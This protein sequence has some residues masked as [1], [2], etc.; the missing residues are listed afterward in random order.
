MP[1]KKQKK[2]QSPL[3][4]RGVMK[5]KIRFDSFEA[6]RVV[7]RCYDRVKYAMFSASVILH[8]ISDNN[9]ADELNSIINDT[10]NTA[11][12]DMEKAKIQFQTVLDDAGIE[13]MLDYTEAKSYTFE[14]DSPK[15]SQYIKAINTLDDLVKM[16]DTAW[17]NGEI[18]DEVKK[19]ACR[20]W[21]KR[22]INMSVKIVK[23]ERKVRNAIH[24]SGKSTDEVE[25]ELE[26]FEQ[27][28][29]KSEESTC[30]AA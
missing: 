27:E 24:E 23:V 26:S 16:I 30:V 2:K 22:L 5:R 12:K 25:T 28:E 20:S 13:E 14:I 3:S 1:D 17:M 6:Q 18:D 11:L 21:Q 4:S 10:I 8:V 15:L 19:D 29:S 9:E 7:E